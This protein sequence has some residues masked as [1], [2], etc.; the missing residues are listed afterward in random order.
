MRSLVAA[1]RPPTQAH[2]RDPLHIQTL[3]GPET[4]HFGPKFFPMTGVKVPCRRLS[5]QLLDMTRQ[6]LVRHAS[7][8]G[9]PFFDMTG[10][11]WESESEMA[12]AL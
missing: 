11:E 3:T 5:G 6:E 1:S 12:R 4:L 8:L 10:D 9:I 2:F 7:R